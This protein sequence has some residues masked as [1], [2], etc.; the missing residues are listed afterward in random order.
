MSAYV[1]PIVE[2]QTEQRCVERLLHRIWE[3]LLGGPERLQVL[4]PFRGRRDALVHPSGLALGQSV[5]KAFLKLQAKAKRE[6]L[7]RLLVLLLLDAEEDCPAELAPRL[8]Q[9]ARNAQANATIACVLAKRMLENWFVASV[10]S[11]AG[12]QDLPQRLQPPEDSESPRGSAW[13]EKQMRSVKRSRK[14]SKTVDAP[15]FVRAMNLRDCRTRPPSFDKLCRELQKLLIAAPE[16]PE[17]RGQDT[18]MPSD[19]D[20]GADS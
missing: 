15:E 11:L 3:E 9:T 7:A 17:P 6:P 8:L 5:Q 20:H 19:P 1:A 12:I 18:A 2:G 10:A 14:Y 4:E 13:L 16:P